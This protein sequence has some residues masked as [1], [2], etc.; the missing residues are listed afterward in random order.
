M[1]MQ[2][3]KKRK[4][5]EH[6]GYSTWRAMKRRCDDPKHWNFQYYGGKGVTICAQWRENPWSF[7]DWL[8]ANGWHDGLSVDRIDDCGDYSPENCRLVTQVQQIRA[9]SSALRITANGKTKTAAEWAEE[10]GIPYG[11]LKVRVRQLG[12]SHE[13]AVNTPVM[14]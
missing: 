2:Y 6:A 5:A 9:K 3:D 7:L 12:W 4:L 13:A 1:A 8:D 14:G 11:T 10:T